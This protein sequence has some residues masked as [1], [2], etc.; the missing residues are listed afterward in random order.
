[1]R[2]LSANSCQCVAIVWKL[3]PPIKHKLKIQYIHASFRLCGVHRIHRSRATYRFD[4]NILLLP[5]FHEISTKARSFPFRFQIN[6]GVYCVQALSDWAVFSEATCSLAHYCCPKLISLFNGKLN[7]WIISLKCT[8]N[9]LLA[10]RNAQTMIIYIFYSDKKLARIYIYYFNNI[11]R[12]D[13]SWREFYDG[14]H[15]NKNKGT[16]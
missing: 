8:C 11:D 2:F 5:K 9:W 10:I 1:M 7:H 15:C 4:I 3:L 14:S 13:W 16:F 12:F 6:A